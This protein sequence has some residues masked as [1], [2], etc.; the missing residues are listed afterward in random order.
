MIVSLASKTDL[1]ILNNLDKH[2]D[3]EELINS[4]SLKRI[5]VCKVKKTIIGWL[6]YNLFWDNTPFMN[7]LYILDSYRNKGYGKLLVETF[8][9]D[10]KNFG[11]NKVMTSTL[12]E[13]EAKDFYYHLG[14][15]KV[16]G[17]SPSKDEYELILE[18]EL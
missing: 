7:M 6:R 4:I 1:E 5:Y 8:E 17:F 18:K 14:Y 9:K 13:E 12:E 11:Y 10:M 3:K 16:G 2:I 15:F